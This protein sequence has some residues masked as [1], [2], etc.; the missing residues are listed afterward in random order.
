M[1]EGDKIF[2]YLLTIKRNAKEFT[3][4]L[5]TN[6]QRDRVKRMG[7]NIEWS[8]H[9]VYK[10][11]S[12]N[13]LHSQYL[14]SSK[15]KLYFSKFKSKGWF[16]YFYQIQ[17]ECYNDVVG[18]LLNE[19]TTNG[20]DVNRLEILSR[21]YWESNDEEKQNFNMNNDIKQSKMIESKYCQLF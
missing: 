17:E 13:R 6:R 12:H 9:Y 11:D 15:E 19:K 8:E 20:D 16:I 14:I 10:L 4:L 7:K 5:W 2:F 18:Y 1:I 21:K 3:P